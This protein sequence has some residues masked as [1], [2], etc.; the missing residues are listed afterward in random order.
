MLLCQPLQ[1]RIPATALGIFS[2]GPTAPLCTGTHPQPPHCSFALPRA[3]CSAL[4]RDTPLSR[5]NCS[6]ALPGLAAPLCTGP[7]PQP[8][9]CSFALPGLAAPALHRAAPLSRRIVALPSPGSL[10]RSVQGRALSHRIVALPSPGSLLRSVQD[11]ALSHR[12]V[13]L[14]L[15]GFAAPLCTGPRPSAAAL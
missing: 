5:R 15:P 3:R 10:L 12:I 9:H 14:P 7:H 4:H 11:R 13:A 1:G 8:P 2:L 6:F